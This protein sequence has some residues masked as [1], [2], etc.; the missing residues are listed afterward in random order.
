MAQ[1]LPERFGRGASNATLH[2]VEGKVFSVQTVSIAFAAWRKVVLS[3]NAFTPWRDGILLCER[4]NQDDLHRSVQEI[5]AAVP[6]PD[7]RLYS[8]IV[9][10]E[11]R[12]KTVNVT[13]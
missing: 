2:R 13:P 10:V 4:A 1:G 9:T 12:D 5:P 8:I 3:S 6:I 11:D 7:D